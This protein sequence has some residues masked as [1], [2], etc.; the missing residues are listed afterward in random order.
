MRGRAAKMNGDLIVISNHGE[1]TTLILK[2]PCARRGWHLR[3][4][5]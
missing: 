3:S 4:R 5:P 2:V 1:G